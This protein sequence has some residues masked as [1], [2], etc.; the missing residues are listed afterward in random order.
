MNANKAITESYRLYEK[1]V[2]FD[3]QVSID[4]I[5]ASILQEFRANR[6]NPSRC[7]IG[8]AKET[9]GD[10]ILLGKIRKAVQS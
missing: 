8:C 7:T 2:S 4:R 6:A 10:L 3:K 9:I 1:W 5:H